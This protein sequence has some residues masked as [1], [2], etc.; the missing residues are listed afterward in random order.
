MPNL[1][2]Q[3]EIDQDLD[4]WQM[5]HNWKKS[6]PDLEEA[7]WLMIFPEAKKRWGRYITGHLKLKIKY[8]NYEKD[9][10]TK[11]AKADLLANPAETAWRDD[12]IKQAARDS[13]RKIEK[14]I[15]RYGHLLKCV[16]DIGKKRDPINKERK[17]KITP[18]LIQKAK[19]YPI[20]NL[21]EI[22]RAGFT[23]CFAH[24]D[25]K[26]SAYCKKNFV[27]CFVCQKSWDT[28]QILI[29]RDGR[30]FRDAVLQLQ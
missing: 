28:I 23:R 21:L 10:I 1:S 5:E 19:E 26:P 8:L 3:E 29:D 15:I 2:E 24:N 17:I 25:K 9:N 14:T 12:L 13:I 20:E 4:M 11:K 30:T 16:A 6:L 22:N 18:E 7:Q 27:H